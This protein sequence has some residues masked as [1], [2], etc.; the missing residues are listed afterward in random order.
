MTGRGERAMST[1]LQIRRNI[2]R[3]RPRVVQ[4]SLETLETLLGPASFT[5]TVGFPAE[6]EVEPNDTIVRAQNLGNITQLGQAGVTGTL[7]NDP[8]SGAGGVDWYQLTLTASTDVHR[9]TLDKAGG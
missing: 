2:P 8:A 9:A 6:T 7:G 3:R 1:T 5:P 4:L